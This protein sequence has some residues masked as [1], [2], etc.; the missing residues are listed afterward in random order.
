MGVRQVSVSA[1]GAQKTYKVDVRIFSDASNTQRLGEAVV[2]LE[3]ERGRRFRMVDGPGVASPSSPLAPHQSMDTTLTFVVPADV[4]RLF[5]TGD[6]PLPDPVP[7][8]WRVASIFADL[9]IGYEK[10]LHKPTLLRVL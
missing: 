6:A 3:D 4:K 7:F 10:L 5:L 9:H 1:D 2:L 8:S